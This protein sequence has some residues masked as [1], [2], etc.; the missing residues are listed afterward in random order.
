MPER[1]WP[2]LVGPAAA[3]GDDEELGLELPQAERTGPTA[4]SAP[5]A[6]APLSTVRRVYL[7]E[8]MTSSILLRSNPALPS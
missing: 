7:W 8:L 5:A 3:D 2:P 1:M 4:A 6:A